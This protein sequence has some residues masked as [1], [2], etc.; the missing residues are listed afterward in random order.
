[1]H[2]FLDS[3]VLLAFCRSKNGA[4]ALIIDNCRHKKLT[5][6]IS[7]K[8]IAEV[9]K[10]NLE[11]ENAI[12]IQR[13]GYILHRRFLTILED[14]T[15]EELKKANKLLNNPKDAVILVSAKQSPNIQ[16]ILSLDSDFFKQKV[17][18]YVKPI[19]ILKPGKFLERFK[20][21]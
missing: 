19:E 2:I 14:G 11:D 15:G 4:S 16:Y 12:G 13:F 9:Q 3:S 21:T 1:M 10:N 18:E 5:G 7:K 20:L 17:K 6:Y 8:V